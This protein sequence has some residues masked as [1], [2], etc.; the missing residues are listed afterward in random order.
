MAVHT[1]EA[2]ERDGDYFGPPL[3]RAARL[4]GVA[5]AGE[6]VVSDV[7][8]GVVAGRAGVEL[9]DRGVHRLRG[10]AEPIHAFSVRAEGL[11]RG[12]EPVPSASDMPRSNLPDEGAPL[13]FVGRRI[14]LDTL[15]AWWR[16]QALSNRMILLTGEA[17]VGKTRL[18]TAFARDVEREGHPVL[19]GRAVEAEGS[20]YEPLLG[21][22]RQFIAHDGDHG[23]GKLGETTAGALSRLLPEVAERRP[24]AAARAAAWGEVDR[25]WLLGAVA[26]CLA[27]PPSEPVLLVLDDLQWADR[28]ALMLLSR[29]L[30]TDKR[31]RVV[32]TYRAAASSASHLGA[33]LAELRRDDRPVRRLPLSGLGDGD[34]VEFMAALGRTEL[35]AAGRTFRVASSS[36][37][38][39]QSVLRAR[40]AASARSERL[41]LGG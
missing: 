2:Q 15:G 11:V 33:F 23:I 37:Y 16:D 24:V 35:S 25:S 41:D 9:V 28:P 20:S 18:A 34:V 39:G 38:R 3:N 10:L 5:R 12:D 17:G 30:E 29:L 36:T 27:G 8:A 22:L 21:A 32:G 6:I 14:E 13:P 26:D 31:A 4:M 7:T 1:G 19:Y 40:D